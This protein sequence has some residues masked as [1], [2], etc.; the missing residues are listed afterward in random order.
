[1]P[2]PNLESQSNTVV[3]DPAPWPAP[4]TFPPLK[5]NEV[6]LWLCRL[7]ALFSK[8]EDFFARILSKEEQ[9][10]AGGITSEAVRRRFVVTRA[11]LRIVLAGYV[12]AEPRTLQFRYGAQGKPYLTSPP[13]DKQLHFSV[14]HSGEFAL[15]GISS[16]GDLGVDI[17]RINKRRDVEQIARRFFTAQENATL[18][19]LSSEARREAVYS[20]WCR[21]EAHAKAV[22]CGI[23]Q[24]LLPSDSPKE[25][26]DF[27]HSYAHSV[28]TIPGYACAVA[29]A[30]PDACITFQAVSAKLAGP[31]SR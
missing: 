26:A 2:L 23:I 21:K 8:S 30:Q 9:K 15:Y 22:G 12:E 13:K 28:S 25:S 18:Q 14:S 24:L 5:K 19:A 7:D 20:L 6:H 17:E 3:V 29:I 27:S 31:P 1:M 11:E 4:S 10:R 16:L